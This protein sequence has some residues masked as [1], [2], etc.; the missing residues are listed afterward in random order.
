MLSRKKTLFR[1]RRRVCRQQR[2]GC[3]FIMP[4]NAPSCAKPIAWFPRNG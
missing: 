1:P 4:S 3:C 2:S